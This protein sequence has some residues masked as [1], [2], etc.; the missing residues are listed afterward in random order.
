MRN[1]KLRLNSDY[2]WFL[3]TRFVFLQSILLI[4]NILLLQRISLIVV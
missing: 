2:E 3:K 1:K 4:A